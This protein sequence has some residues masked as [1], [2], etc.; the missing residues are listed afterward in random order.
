MKQPLPELKPA[1]STV[2][3][4]AISF[5]DLGFAA[6]GGY[7]QRIVAL[8][9]EPHADMIR[10]PRVVRERSALTVNAEAAR[11]LRLPTWHYLAGRL[12][13]FFGIYLQ[14]QNTVYGPPF[15]DTLFTQHMSG[16][17][18]H[19][20]HSAREAYNAQLNNAAQPLGRQI[21]YR[22]H[23]GQVGVFAGFNEANGQLE[24]CQTV[25][26]LGLRSGLHMQIIG[27]DG[28]LVLTHHTDTT[29]MFPKGETTDT[30]VRISPGL[31]VLP[32]PHIP[33]SR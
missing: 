3:T 17:R 26:G 28:P 12:N 6:M 30:G 19:D 32:A 14:H 1:E 9:P 8:R 22:L 31:F 27:D 7:A 23:L 21:G 20:V 33:K 2:E 24:A 11:T 13:E 4:V 15:D 16:N 25:L 5:A 29:K 18:S 10:V